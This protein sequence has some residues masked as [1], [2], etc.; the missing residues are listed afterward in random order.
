VAGIRFAYSRVRRGLGVEQI[1]TTAKK[2]GLLYS[3]YSSTRMS[4]NHLTCPLWMDHKKYN[5]IS[6]ARHIFIVELYAT[7]QFLKGVYGST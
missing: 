2:P 1:Q 6:F 7:E 5:L 3:F 4:Q